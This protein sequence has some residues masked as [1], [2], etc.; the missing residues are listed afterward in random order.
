MALRHR[1]EP[2]PLLY[3][4]ECEGEAQRVYVSF[5][6]RGVVC[7]GCFES[8]EPFVRQVHRAHSPPMRAAIG[9]A[10]LKKYRVPQS[11]H[12]LWR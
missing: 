7:Q 2:L 8:E 4:Y 9:R 5:V 1:V 12:F 6:S 11:K 10:L 3:C